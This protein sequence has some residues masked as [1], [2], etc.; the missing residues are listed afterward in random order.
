VARRL[1]ELA[2]RTK[3]K[4]VTDYR[5]LKPYIPDHIKPA[6]VESYIIRALEAYREQE[7]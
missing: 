7:E 4:H 5:N 6:E 2:V 1:P 3:Q